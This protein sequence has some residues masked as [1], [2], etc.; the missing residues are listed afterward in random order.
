MI[1]TLNNHISRDKC[2]HL[3][4]AGSIWYDSNKN[5]GFTAVPSVYCL[6]IHKCRDDCFP[7]G[8]A[9]GGGGRS[10]LKDAEAVSPLKVSDK[11]EPFV[12]PSKQFP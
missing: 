9:G 1:K 11:F 5:A 10:S 8:N 6:A 12:F 4:S 3:V 2:L 7:V